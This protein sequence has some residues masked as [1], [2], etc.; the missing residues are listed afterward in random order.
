MAKFCPINDRQ[1]DEHI[2][3]LNALLVVT[4]LSLVNNRLI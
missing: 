3:R 2:V 1:T 4:L